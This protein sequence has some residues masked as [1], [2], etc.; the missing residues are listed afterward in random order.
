MGTT[1]QKLNYAINATNDIA[2][3]IN[4]ISGEITSETPLG[5]FS[6]ELKAIWERLPKI[7]PPAS[8]ELYFQALR[9]RMDKRFRGDTSQ[10]DG[11]SPDYPQDIQVVKGKQVVKFNKNTEYYS[12]YNLDLKSKNLFDGEYEVGSID[13]NTGQPIS[14]ATNRRTKNFIEVDSNNSLYISLSENPLLYNPRIYFYDTNKNYL[15]NIRG[16]IGES[17][18]IPSNTKYIKFISGD[19]DWTKMYVVY[20]P[21]YNYELCKIDTAE[22]SIY[23]NKQDGKWYLH[24]EIGKAILNGSESWSSWGVG[25]KNNTQAYVFRDMPSISDKDM[26]ANAGCPYI[27]NRFIFYSNS[28]YQND[29]ELLYLNNLKSCGIRLSTSKAPDV[30]TFKTWLSNNNV[31]LYYILAI[32]TN[33]EITSPTLISQL[34]SLQN[35]RSI[36]GTNTITSQCEEGLPVRIGVTALMKQV[37]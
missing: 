20:E 16:E 25:N 15:S 24:K 13:T 3:G 30:A 17:V 28:N 26:T 21:Y 27:C 11:A 19:T 2:E 37:V 22:D 32:S 12:Q 14:H 4:D 9:G 35:Q 31:T 1:A 7:T 10:E 33:T 6:D 5:D 34:E 23:K 8:N 36:D 18:S 29:V